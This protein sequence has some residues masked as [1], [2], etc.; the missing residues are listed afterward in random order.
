[1]T[2]NLS[3][4]NNACRCR[5]CNKS[6][7]SMK[8]LSSHLT[9]MA[10]HPTPEE[11]YKKYINT[12]KDSGVCPTCGNSTAFI[13][14][15]KGYRIYC[16]VKCCSSSPEIKEK[17]RETCLKKYGET[18]NLKTEDTKEK[19]KKT[20]LERYGTEHPAQSD[21]VKTRMRD[22]LIEKYGVDSAMKNED[23]KAKTRNTLVERYG[24]DNPL[25]SE[26]IKS[27]VRK[28]V[29][30]KYGVDCVFQ[31]DVIKEKIATTNLVRYGVENPSKTFE[32]KKKI[33]NTIQE[34]YGVEW[35]MQSEKIKQKSAKTCL[36]KYGV[37]NVFK[38]EDIKEK[39]KQLYIEK[40]GEDN[41]AKSS[42]VKEKMR[43]T[44]LERYGVDNFMKTTEYKE[45]IREKYRDK[46][47]DKIFNKNRL[48]G[49]VIPKFEPSMVNTCF[50]IY[51]W[52]CCECSTIFTSTLKN[53][54]IPRCPKC[55]PVK[56]SSSKMEDE[57]ADFCESLN[58]GEIIRNTKEIIKP[59]ELDI[60][61]PDKRIAIEMN[62]L[63]WHSEIGGKKDKQYHIN[64]TDMCLDEGVSLIQVY[65]DEWFNKQDIVKSILKSKLGVIDNK[66][67]AR[68]CKI[69]TIENDIAI[70]FLDDNHLQGP[71]NGTH[72][73][74]EF[75]G[76]LV[77]M[78]TIGKCRFDKRY[79]LE[80]LRFCNKI[81]TMVVGG[82]SK[83][84]EYIKKIYKNKS[85]V[86]Y[87][88]KR[89]GSGKFYEYVG[90]VFDGETGPG[91]YYITDDYLLRETRY[92][93]QKYM[94]ENKIETYDEALTEWENMQLNGYD[95][96]WDCGNAKWKLKI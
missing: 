3:N 80:I 65:E 33:S 46:L 31:S 87:V 96:I 22:T 66:I 30:D 41:P 6:F 47:I 84:F 40:Y 74:L 81:N 26:E 54:I 28:T 44:N 10:D 36:E 7:K 34:R 77:C 51:N 95:R 73:G 15:D 20:S 91:F 43:K 83:I 1:M 79:D 5:I 57:L 76:E 64:K 14:L 21:V 82:F 52:Q 85:I 58:V 69:V 23:V 38:S 12:S 42:V 25:K 93:Y 37:D 32:V 71:I 8:G 55:Y 50:D 27:K 13:N 4:S 24:V 2:Q 18:T 90:F 86:T 94:L 75:D 78:I 63:Y 89:F 60:Y 29:Q 16:S 68:K 61:I 48:G 67:Y 19:I 70:E 53:G 17:K 92:K 56:L 49:K 45:N 9:Q 39:C 59:Y 62:G 72:I 11:Y 88:D 35:A